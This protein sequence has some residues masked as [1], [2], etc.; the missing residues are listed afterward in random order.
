MQT[1]L[2]HAESSHFKGALLE[3]IQIVARFLTCLLPWCFL[4]GAAPTDVVLSSVAIL[5]ILRSIL[6]KNNTWL[7]S[8]WVKVA[9]G[10]WMYLIVTN[11]LMN[12]FALAMQHSLPWGRF[13]LFAAALEFWVLLDTTWRQRFWWSLGGVILF[14][15]FC[16][17]FE[18]IFGLDVRGQPRIDVHRLVGP[19][20]RPKVGVFLIKA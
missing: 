10:I 1:G 13:V 5:F 4:M 18:Y 11:L 9:M 17:L 19:F 2:A 20:R 15:F 8:A 3:G 6:V 14:T 16:G 7:K 12:G